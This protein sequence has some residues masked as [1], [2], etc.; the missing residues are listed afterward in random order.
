MIITYYETRTGGEPEDPEDRWTSHAP[1]YIDW[2]VRGVF[3]DEPGMSAKDKAKSWVVQEVKAD[4]VPKPGDWITLVTVRYQTGST[5][6]TTHGCWEIIGAYKTSE[7]AQKMADL[8]WADENQCRKYEQEMREHQ[9]RKGKKP[10]VPKNLYEGYKP[11]RGYFENLEDI[12]VE[13][14]KVT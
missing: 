9:Y 2:G 12:Q 13:S 5:F 11:W 1:E 7:E 6:G 3:V 10:E 14:F 4:F 8:I